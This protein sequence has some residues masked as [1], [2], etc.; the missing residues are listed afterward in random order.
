MSYTSCSTLCLNI[1]YHI[2]AKQRMQNSFFYHMQDLRIASNQYSAK[3]MHHCRSTVMMWTDALEHLLF[4]NICSVLTEHG[5]ALTE[6][7]R[8]AQQFMC[9]VAQW[10]LASIP[11]IGKDAALEDSSSQN[12]L[13]TNLKEKAPDRAPTGA[14]CWSLYCVGNDTCWLSFRMTIMFLSR[15]PAWFIAS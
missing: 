14:C 15:N 4:I 9:A 2:T 12:T 6:R 10:L 8:K 3:I 11:H 13:N 5:S 7:H 1:V